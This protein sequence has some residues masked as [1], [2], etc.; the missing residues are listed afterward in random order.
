MQPW[1][2]DGELFLDL[3]NAIKIDLLLLKAEKMTTKT[4]KHI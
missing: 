2:G 4:V 1:C 3:S